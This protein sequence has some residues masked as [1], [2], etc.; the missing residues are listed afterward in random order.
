MVLGL[1]IA[2]CVAPNAFALAGTANIDTSGTCS[3]TSFIPGR[4]GQSYYPQADVGCSRSVAS[5]EVQVCGAV[6]NAD[7]Q[8]YAVNGSC[9]PGGSSYGNGH[10]ADFYNTNGVPLV[11]KWDLGVCGH[12][13]RTQSI[14]GDSTDGYD[15]YGLP[16]SSGETQC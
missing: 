6:Y 2:L 10:Y 13:Y 16:I 7:G 14:G 11:G 4:D 12:V 3:M 15:L 8:W 9:Y 5:I 1:A